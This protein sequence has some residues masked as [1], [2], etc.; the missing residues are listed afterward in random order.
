MAVGFSLGLSKFPE[1]AVSVAHG[2]IGLQGAASPDSFGE[3]AESTD[4]VCVPNW[5]FMRREISSKWR[6][7]RKASPV[8][9]A[10]QI[11]KRT[12]STAKT[13]G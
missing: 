5:V 12:V 7:E 3:T 2:E 1:V 11:R 9:T 13:P 8:A 10:P 4:A 6:R